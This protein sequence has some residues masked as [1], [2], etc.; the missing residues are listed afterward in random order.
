MTLAAG[1]TTEVEFVRRE[2]AVITGR[3]TGL[4]NS[5]VPGV[6]LHV[7]PANKT[8]GKRRLVLD[9]LTCEPSGEFTTA[10]IPPWKYLVVAAAYRPEGRIIY[11]GIRRADFSGAVEVTVPSSGRLEPVVIEM[12]KGSR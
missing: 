9:L 4:P 12:R 8:E 11:G 7:E 1:K 2:G 6:F 5:A 3:V 10:R